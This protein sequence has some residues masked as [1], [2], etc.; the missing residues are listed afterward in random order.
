MLLLCGTDF[1]FQQD[2]EP[3]HIAGS[4]M[5]L[6]GRK[7]ITVSPWPAQSPDPNPIEHLWEI[8]KKNIRETT[9]QEHG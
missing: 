3:C 7:G 9:L 5:A 6:F 8:M 1:V 4:T 2:G